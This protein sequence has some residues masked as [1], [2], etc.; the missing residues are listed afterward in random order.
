VNESSP[1]AGRARRA[2]APVTRPTEPMTRPTAPMATQPVGFGAVDA[3]AVLSD[4]MTGVEL[5]SWDR[6]VIDWMLAHEP[7]V[8]LTFASLIQRAREAARGEAVGDPAP[9]AGRF[10]RPA[11]RLA[12]V[13]EPEP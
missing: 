10:H 13:P 5:G 1:E 11:G 9:E 6:A 4:A 12:V 8:V 7:C 3:F 2:V